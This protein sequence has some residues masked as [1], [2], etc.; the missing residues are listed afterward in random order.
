MSKQDA[1][2]ISADVGKRWMVWKSFGVKVMESS[3]K[4]EGC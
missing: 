1:K 4:I 3:W 2:S